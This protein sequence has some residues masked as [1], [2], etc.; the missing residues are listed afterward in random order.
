MKER[1]VEKRT[2]TLRGKSENITERRILAW[3]AFVNSSHALVFVQRPTRHDRVVKTTPKQRNVDSF[4]YSLLISAYFGSE[5]E[6]MWA[7]Y[8]PFRKRAFSLTSFFVSHEFKSQPAPVHS[9]DR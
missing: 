7:V 1:Q 9:G 4:F 3:N 8:W 5:P 2:P 6:G